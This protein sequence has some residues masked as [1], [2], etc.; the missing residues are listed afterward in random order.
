MRLLISL[1]PAIPRSLFNLESGILGNLFSS[2]LLVYLIYYRLARLYGLLVQSLYPDSEAVDAGISTDSPYYVLAGGTCPTV[3]VTGHV[4]C[5]GY[6]MF[7]R[8]IGE[9][10]FSM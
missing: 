9:E 3:G 2:I 10:L 5:G 7:G 4:V 6:G 1:I 8:M